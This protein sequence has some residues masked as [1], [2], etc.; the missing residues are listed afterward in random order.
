MLPGS[1]H[2]FSIEFL[3]SA[4][5]DYSGQIT[6]IGASKPLGQLSAH[7]RGRGNQQATAQLSLD[8]NQLNFGDVAV[9]SSSTQTVTLTYSGKL[10]VTVNPATITG[11]GFAIV[12]SPLPATLNPGQSIAIQVLF[13]P[14]SIGVASGQISIGN[15]SSSNE[16]VV[17]LN[18]KGTAV[19]SSPLSSQLTVSTDSLSFGGVSLDTDTT[20]PILFKLHG[21]STRQSTRSYSYWGGF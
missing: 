21:N 17:A 19:S 7:G 4:A 11:T 8:T 18:G 12:G 10:P 1:S 13:T 3:P 6:L 15:E 9:N 14:K 2:I 16:M 5:S 20:K